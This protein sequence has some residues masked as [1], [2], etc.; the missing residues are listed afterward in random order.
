MKRVHLP[1][2]VIITLFF[3]WQLTTVD[4]GT[5]IND[6]DYIRSYTVDS[7][8]TSG[9]GLERRTVVRRKPRPRVPRPVDDALQA[10]QHRRR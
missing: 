5:R 4:F 2:F 6:I 1:A 7:D 10:L 9:S 8:V 3:A